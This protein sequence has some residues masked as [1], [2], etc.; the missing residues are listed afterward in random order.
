MGRII[1]GLLASLLLVCPLS[2]RAN[3]REP[4]LFDF[5][6]R[7]PSDYGSCTMMKY[8]SLCWIPINRPPVGATMMF[9]LWDSRSIKPVLEVPLP[10]SIQTGKNETCY[11]V[12]LKDY[13]IQLE[14]DILYRWNISIDE[15]PESPSHD[16][17]LGGLIKRCSEKGCLIQEMPSRYDRNFVRFLASRGFFYDS[18]SC[19]CELIKSSPDDETLKRM[20]DELML[21]AGP[22]RIP[23]EPRPELFFSSQKQLFLE[24]AFAITRQRHF[25]DLEEI[26]AYGFWHAIK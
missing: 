17:V 21:E 7:L 11:C 15:N 4:P 14:P 25:N 13:D 3:T 19:L 9:T 10:N 20:L 8:P 26:S 24:L 12:N 22:K 5:L 23:T 16:V 18:I 6:L 2:A 1:L